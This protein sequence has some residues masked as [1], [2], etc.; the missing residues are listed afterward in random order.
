MDG[1][2]ARVR[3]VF[4]EEL[5]GMP[6]DRSVEFVI[7]LVP[8]TAPIS[9]RPY[10]MDPEEFVEL[11]RQIEEL[12]EKGFIQLSDQW[13]RGYPDPSAD[14]PTLASNQWAKGGAWLGLPGQPTVRLLR[15]STRSRLAREHHR[16]GPLERS[17]PGQIGRASCR[18]RVCLY[19]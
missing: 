15:T 17:S 11:K 14:R 13:V 16:D 4:P 2:P 3:D 19:V 12:E 18:E 10:F 9:K 6:P 5:P 8:R 7:E 1:V